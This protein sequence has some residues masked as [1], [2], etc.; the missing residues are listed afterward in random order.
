MAQPQTMPERSDTIRS[1]EQ[2]S[3][4]YQLGLTGK[5]AVERQ[6]RA[7]EA[8]SANQRGENVVRHPQ[9]MDG[10]H[11]LVFRAGSAMG[12]QVR[13]ADALDQV[14]DIA[15]STRVVPVQGGGA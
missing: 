6:L 14:N 1:W 8:E 5:D 3:A 13:P 12:D 10:G 2:R 15:G 11:P 7:I 9:K 4:P